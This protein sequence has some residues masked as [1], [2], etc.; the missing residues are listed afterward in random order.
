MKKK[1][2]SSNST[3]T[4]L[5]QQIK[6]SS[7]M[8]SNS[9]Y[10]T[11]PIWEKVYL[12]IKEVKDIDS[13]FSFSSSIFINKKVYIFPKYKSPSSHYAIFDTS[14]EQIAFYPLQIECFNPLHDKQTNLI[15]LFSYDS[16][17]GSDFRYNIIEYNP[18]NNSFT[19]LVMKGVAPK[20]RR[21]A[22]TSFIFDGKIYFF[23]GVQMFTGDNS[24]NYLFS[25]NIKECE[26]NIEKYNGIF[27][28]DNMN[29]GYIINTFNVIGVEVEEGSGDEKGKVILIGGKYFDDVFY[30]NMSITTKI[31][32]AK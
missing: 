26:W 16:S 3:S 14:T 19:N 6:P 24:M 31:Q 8:N 30:S 17:Y 11:F 32:N 25:F 28:S 12:D 27:H 5:N 29:L 7:P 21:E 23:G 1:T 4:N 10:F 15:Y 20:A 18:I 2:Q 22:F 9:Q 13:F